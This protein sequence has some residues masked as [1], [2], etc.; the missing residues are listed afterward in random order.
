MATPKQYQAQ[1]LSMDWTA[2]AEKI[3]QY[4]S[5]LFKQMM[6]G[7]ETVADKA[8]IE[9]GKQRTSDETRTLY[10]ANAQVGAATA[11]ARGQIGAALE[12]SRAAI[13]A[14]QLERDKF[15][16][17]KNAGLGLD[18]VGNVQNRSVDG[19]GTG[20][21]VSSTTGGTGFGNWSAPTMIRAGSTAS[22]FDD[23]YGNY[24]RNLDY[25]YQRG[26]A[27]TTARMMTQA[28][29][30][31][32][33]ARARAQAQ[34]QRNTLLAQSN[35]DAQR[36]NREAA[37]KSQADANARR[38]QSQE[39]DKDRINQRFIAGLDANSRLFGSLNQGQG[40][41]QYWGGSI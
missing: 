15:N 21:S 4:N 35:A 39:A 28:E 29:A 19:V 7:Y 11:S 40:G 36:M 31:G 9:A 26:Q 22:G 34:E 33:I 2:N 30:A 6:Q 23:V 3:K 12:N 17:N 20:R 5:D 16:I 10:G 8:A 41:F 14:Q 37:L 24:R 1:Q 27:A 38:F 18:A 25:Q 13:M 32:D